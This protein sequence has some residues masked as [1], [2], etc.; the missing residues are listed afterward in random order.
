MARASGARATLLHIEELIYGVPPGSGYR[1][2]PF[3]SSTLSDSQPLQDSDLLGVGRDPVT[4]MRDAITVDGNIVVPMDRR[5]I[6][7]WLKAT[8]GAPVTTGSGPYTHVFTSGSWTLPA[9]SLELGFPEVPHFAMNSGVMV[10]ELSFQVQ[11]GGS[12]NCTLGLIGKTTRDATV[13]EDATALAA[14]IGLYR[15]GNFH[16]SIKRNGAALANAVSASVTYSNTLDRIEGIGAEILGLDPSAAKASGS[17]VTRFADTTL[18]Q[19]AKDGGPCELE[20]AFTAAP[21]SITWAFPFVMLPVPR[22]EVSGPAGIQVTYDWT[23]M[24]E[25]LGTHMVEVTL[26]NDV[27]SY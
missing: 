16:G 22:R 11:R 17:L 14:E 5:G 15:F 21:Y 23:A 3:I 26:I 19:Q 18:L 24:R 7:H 6:G 4:P 13:S 2:L 1:R 25:E 9:M 8:F 12:P 10:N 20:I 27:A